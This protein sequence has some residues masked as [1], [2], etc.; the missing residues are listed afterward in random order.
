ME[1]LVTHYPRKEY[2][3][4]LMGRVQRKPNF[5]D[6]LVLDTYRLMLATGS[7]RSASDYMEM[8]Q[9]AVQAGLAGEGVQV[10]DKG[11]VAGVLGT[12][13]EAERHKRLKDLV[14]KR[15]EEEK[16]ALATRQ[17]AAAS[18][19]SGNDL[20]DLGFSQAFLGDPKKGI[21][22]MEQG[23]AKGG[24]KRPEDA[25]LHLGI[26]YVQSGQNAKAQGTLKGV[27][28]ADGTADLARLWSLVVRS[29]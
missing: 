29:K 11:F 13:A 10:V 16:Q 2:W 1:K 26:A 3:A 7:M 12:G 5:S 14:V 20:V 17:A 27:G 24:L 15:A 6:R 4:D 23:I 8:A 19:K 28:G 25:R 18:A 9:L 22:M 21:A